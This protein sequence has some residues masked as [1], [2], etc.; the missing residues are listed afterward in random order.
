MSKQGP[1]TFE[2]GYEAA[3]EEIRA[4]IASWDDHVWNCVDCPACETIREFKRWMVDRLEE[5]M[6]EEQQSIFWKVA[7]AWGLADIYGW[8]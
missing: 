2:R 6:G 3:H 8:P 4:A 7:S 5:R 1:D